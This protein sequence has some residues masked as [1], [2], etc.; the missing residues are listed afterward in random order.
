M[1]GLDDDSIL[2][3]GHLAGG[4]SILSLL[5][6]EFCSRAQAAQVQRGCVA[7]FTGGSILR[8]PDLKLQNRPPSGSFSAAESKRLVMTVAEL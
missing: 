6:A 7:W 8:R 3:C 4:N 5:P 1:G 2:S